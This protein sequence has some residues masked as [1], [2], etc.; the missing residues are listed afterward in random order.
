[1]T[2]EEL[3]EKY[4]GIFKVLI[5]TAGD[6]EENSSYQNVAHILKEKGSREMIRRAIDDE[7]DFRVFVSILIFLVMRDVHGI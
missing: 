6:K 2:C 3:Y 1:M 7:V 5:K 4:V